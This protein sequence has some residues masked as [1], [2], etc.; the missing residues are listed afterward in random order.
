MIDD[1]P[2]EADSVDCIISNCVINLAADKHAVFREMARVLKPGGST[3]HQRHLAQKANPSRSRPGG[4]WPTS[5]A[6]GVIPIEEYKQG[7]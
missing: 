4:S 2:L 6:F 5:A 1:L 7:L 3:G